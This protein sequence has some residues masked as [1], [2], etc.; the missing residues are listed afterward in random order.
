MTNYNLI[1]ESDICT[2]SFSDFESF[3][4]LFQQAYFSDNQ[5][6][7]F[8]LEKSSPD[9]FQ[10]AYIRVLPAI[11]EL[12]CDSGISPILSSHTCNTLPCIFN[13]LFYLTG[14]YSVSKGF[15]P[16][17][18][19]RAKSSRQTNPETGRT[20]Y[21]FSPSSLWNDFFFSEPLLIQKLREKKIRD[22]S[23][24]TERTREFYEGAPFDYYPPQDFI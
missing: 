11:S 3:F 14:S 17:L 18:L 9:F 24:L 12:S 19:T 1:H 22:F 5:D 23:E 20:E 16:Q 7:L 2:L 6:M 15:L 8:Q 10:R 21:C 13:M 4:S